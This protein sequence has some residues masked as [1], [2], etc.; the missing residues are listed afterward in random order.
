M[1]S[2]YEPYFYLNIPYNP[3]QPCYNIT[4]ELRENHIQ[5]QTTLKENYKV[6]NNE[7]I[8]NVEITSLIPDIS[9]S[10]QMQSISNA[11]QTKINRKRKISIDIYN[12]L[13]S[14][15]P[16][17]SPYEPELP[18]HNL[19]PNNPDYLAYEKIISNNSYKENKEINNQDKEICDHKNPINKTDNVQ[20]EICGFK[21]TSND[22]ESNKPEM[23]EN[24]GPDSKYGGGSDQ[25]IDEILESLG[26]KDKITETSIETPT[27]SEQTFNEILES[28]GMRDK[29]TETPTLSIS[30]MT[31]DKIAKNIET[32]L[33]IS[34]HS[35]PH[36]EQQVQ[37][38]SKQRKS[39]TKEKRKKRKSAKERRKWKTKSNIENESR[40]HLNEQKEQERTAET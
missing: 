26:M 13:E 30:K 11:S 35:Q 18:F 27:G 3:G 37:S 4:P 2:Y 38:S 21:N 10:D 5:E 15:I 31:N 40:K 39:R 36:K 32:P 9:P 7:S 24:F 8:E 23:N 34:D 29:I 14:E 28:L 12:D 19:A 25:D 6:N 16:L 1:D 22:K 20:V 33:L 17:P